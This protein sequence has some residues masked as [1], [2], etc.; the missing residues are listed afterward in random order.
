MDI[1]DSSI[2]LG[3]G[4]G[5]EE[6]NT[7]SGTGKGLPEHLQEMFYKSSINLSGEQQ[8]RFREL[9]G[10]HSSVFSSSDL[11]LGEFSA[12]KYTIETGATVPSKQ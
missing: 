4:A 12:I 6:G 5:D 11:D 7:V 10:K 8:N 3:K 9:L 2:L 1:L